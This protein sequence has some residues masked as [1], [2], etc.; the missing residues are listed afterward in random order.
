MTLSAALDW[1]WP[2]PIFIGIDLG[3][4]DLSSPAVEPT[5]A[6]ALATVVQTGA[7]EHPAIA[8]GLPATPLR[9]DGGMTFFSTSFASP[10]TSGMTC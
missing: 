6:D 7:G 1:M 5:L 8:S 10:P 4:P 3:G 9:S 2:A